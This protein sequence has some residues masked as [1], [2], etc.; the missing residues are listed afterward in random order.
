MACQKAYKTEDQQAACWTRSKWEPSSEHHFLNAAKFSLTVA[1]C[2]GPV[3]EPAGAARAAPAA[4]FAPAPAAAACSAPA[5]RCL[6]EDGSSAAAL[7][8]AVA[9]VGDAARCVNSFT[10]MSFS[11]GVGA[12]PRGAAT[13]TSVGT[14]RRSSAACPLGVP[15]PARLTARSPAFRASATG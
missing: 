8:K 15:S 12:A 13:S 10:A 1:R 3:E 2:M 9:A 14:N 6:A 5:S 11:S 7:R 4:E